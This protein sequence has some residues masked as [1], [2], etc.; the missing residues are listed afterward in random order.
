MLI[1]YVLINGSSYLKY[2]HCHNY[3]K[4][5]LCYCETAMTGQNLYPPHHIPSQNKFLAMP[6]P[7]PSKIGSL[8]DNFAN[9]HDS[10][11]GSS[12][13]PAP[14]LASPKKP[15]GGKNTQRKPDYNNFGRGKG[16]VVPPSH[17]DNK[18]CYICDSSYHLAGNCPRG[19]GRGNTGS[20][21]Y[22]QARLRL[23]SVL[24]CIIR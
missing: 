1:N 11:Y 22:R 9:N 4:R 6:L 12:K 5:A 15:I 20:V 16:S 2:L 3:Y 14:R 10:R 17:F 8:A 7:L 19:R 21:T 13:P 23:M 24:H 18:R